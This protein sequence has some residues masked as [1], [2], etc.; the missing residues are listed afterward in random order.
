MEDGKAILDE[1][2]NPLQKITY[3]K[4]DYEFAV[5]FE[6]DPSD[7]SV[8]I[9]IVDESPKIVYDNEELQKYT[10]VIIPGRE[11]EFKSSIRTC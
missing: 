2:G 9:V 1:E 5:N 3:K 8:R 4:Q 11:I 6:E 10:N 7:A